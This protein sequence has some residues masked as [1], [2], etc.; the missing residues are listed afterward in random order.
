M[1]KSTGGDSKRVPRAGAAASAEALPVKSAGR[2]LDL[3]E[4]IAL[5]DAPMT[6]DELTRALGAPKSS[7]LMLLRTLVGRGYL[8]HGEDGRY[9][10]DPIYRIDSGLWI[11]GRAAALRRLARG[12]MQALVA[13]VQET[14]LLGVLSAD[15]QV[16]IIEKVVSPR[17][18]RYDTAVPGLAPAYCTALGR[19]M[20]AFSPHDTVE[21][22]IRTVPMVKVTPHT[23]VEPDAFRADLTQVRQ[24]GYAV[25]H[26]GHLQGAC[27]VATPLFTQDGEVIGALNVGCVTANFDANH[28]SI[29][30]NLLESAALL[31]ARL[32]TL[33]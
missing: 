31:N 10:L 27:S 2:I 8:R 14:A 23:I 17:A 29:T 28:V 22:Y 13:K 16:Q 26:E 20:L 4:R 21:R 6:L 32:G 25:N 3:L 11:G 18:V 24:Q 12:E 5:R 19:S 15:L 1:K 7:T 9:R 33:A 30:R